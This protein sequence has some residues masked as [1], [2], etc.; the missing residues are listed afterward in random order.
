MVLFDA[1]T[2]VRN[3]SNI[4]DASLLREL[5]KVFIQDI[6]WYVQSDILRPVLHLQM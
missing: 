5:W 4:F 3:L 2:F 1:N 6:P